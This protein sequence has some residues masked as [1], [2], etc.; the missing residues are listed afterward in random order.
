MAP[1]TI[2][3]T[4]YDAPGLERE[5]L[6]ERLKFLQSGTGYGLLANLVSTGVVVGSLWGSASTAH[7]ATWLAF[8][9]FALAMRFILHRA[10]IRAPRS[11]GDNPHWCR[12]VTKSASAIGLA[13]AWF[14]LVLL[15]FLGPDHGLVLMSLV[16][17]LVTGHTIA[18][19]RAAAGAFL[20]LSG[21]P[22]VTQLLLLGGPTGSIASALLLILLGMQWV[23]LEIYLAEI[24]KNA[25]LQRQQNWAG[26]ERGEYM[27]SIETANRLFA[28]VLSERELAVTELKS[29][30]QTA[31]DASRA[32]GEF[33][34]YTS[35]EIRTPLNA[36]IGLTR[37]LLDTSLTDEQRDY[38]RRVRNAGHRLLS[39]IN[40]LLDMSKIEAGK[41]EI[42][43]GD[44]LLR[45]LLDDVVQE[46]IVRARAKGIGLDLEVGVDVPNFLV[47]DSFRLSQ[48]LLNLVGNGIKF[49]A[50]GKVTINASLARCEGDT[51]HLLFTVIDTGIGI[52]REK[53]ST[54]FQRYSQTEIG[55]S[56]KFGGTGLGLAISKSLCELM[57]GTIGL[58]SQPDKGS[59][60]F[61]ELPFKVRPEAQG[62]KP[63]YAG[64]A[65]Q[66]RRALKVLVA[67][68]DED[69]RLLMEL[70]LKRKGAQITV[71]E[72][73]QLAVTKI[74][75]N[76][77]DL[78]LMDLEMP[79]MGGF[80]AV[81]AIRQY[82]A[83]VG[84]HVPVVAL[85]AHALVGYREKCVAAGM[86][87][88]L[89]KPVDADALFALMDAYADAQAERTL[90]APGSSQ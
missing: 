77:F 7:L 68:D 74:E 33:L 63:G 37:V 21:L 29:A 81:A 64:G 41:L 65:T 76:H 79:V 5:R 25:Q 54:L 34:A 48:I 2:T 66:R 46:Q 19:F 72:N 88:Y 60:F 22:L 31:E 24:T 15:P 35:H 42:E 70:L 47:G 40:G 45:G 89:T 12:L 17:V 1:H 57:S 80:E 36:V 4:D 10:Y 9:L 23:S 49:T 3:Q 78:V 55:T 26:L 87:D 71:V 67:E 58:R 43:Y 83:G 85:S 14:G 82:E 69:N 18:P 86:D 90:V 62:S 56:R 38:L 11:L 27:R 44:F 84:G 8:M 53:Q 73:G 6:A 28:Q 32:K 16:L 30:K 50:K 20:V 39:L 52:P 59:E 13:W 51:A 75:Q 61:F